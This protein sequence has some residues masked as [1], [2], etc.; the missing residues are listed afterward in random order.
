MSFPEASWLP[1]PRP[2]VT[3]TELAGFAGNAQ[4]DTGRAIRERRREDITQLIPRSESNQ[5]TSTNCQPLMGKGMQEPRQKG[6]MFFCSSKTDG[7]KKGPPKGEELSLPLLFARCL[8]SGR[9]PCGQGGL[10]AIHCPPL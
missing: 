9:L 5:L 3:R 6:S 10:G 8:G 7:N 1:P 2:D 4:G